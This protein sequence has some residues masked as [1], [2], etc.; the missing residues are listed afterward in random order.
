MA[1]Y[2]ALDSKVASPV[3]HDPRASETPTW[4]GPAPNNGWPVAEVGTQGA[5]D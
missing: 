4:P 3:V 1:V 5:A 2:S